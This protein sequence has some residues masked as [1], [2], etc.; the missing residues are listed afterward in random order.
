VSWTFTATADALKR[1]DLRTAYHVL[2]WGVRERYYEWWYGIESSAVVSVADLGTDPS[3]SELYEPTSYLTVNTVFSRIRPR[4]R[5]E[6]AVLLD[7][8]CGMGRVVLAAA[9]YPYAKVIGIEISER[10]LALARQNVARSSR[11]RQCA[12]IRL[13]QADA[14][15][16]TVPDDVTAIFFYNPFRGETMRRFIESIRESLVRR[17]REVTIVFVNPWHFKA[18]EYAW[19]SV[20]EE[21]KRFYPGMKGGMKIGIYRARL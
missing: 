10:L 5:S 3:T 17:N 21:I 7:V 13:E 14:S 16:Y 8:G 19:I 2:T 20:V 12:D 18:E 9:T 4:S 6:N 15:R 1:G 11:G